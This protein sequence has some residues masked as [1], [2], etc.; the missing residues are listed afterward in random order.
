MQLSSPAFE[1]EQPI[2]AL[3]TCGGEDISPELVISGV[4]EGVASLALVMDDPDAPGGTWDHWIV[5]DLPP[6]TTRLEKNAAANLPGGAVHGHNS[7]KR[8]TYGGPCPPSGTH[9]Y[10]FTLYALG[11]RLGLPAGATKAQL[12]ETIRGHVLARA[13]LVGTYSR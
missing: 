9:R 4:P 5:L 10:V 6:N 3:Y 1:H 12:E 13:T 7:W 8:N 2:P 11:T